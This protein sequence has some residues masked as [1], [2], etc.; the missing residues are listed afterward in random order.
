[1]KIDG[2]ELRSLSTCL[3]YLRIIQLLI[4]YLVI[5]V[6]F[7]FLYLF[8]IVLQ[9]APLSPKRKQ[10][11]SGCDPCRPCCDGKRDASHLVILV[12]IF[13][14]FVLVCWCFVDAVL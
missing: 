5:H 7:V 8:W 13:L 4:D 2:R 12:D 11:P 1:M 3:V 6:Y 10:A 14:Y 9:P